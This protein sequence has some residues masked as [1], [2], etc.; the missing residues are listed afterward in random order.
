MKLLLAALL[1]CL[2]HADGVMIS[3]D[4]ST[5]LEMVGQKSQQ[6]WID[7]KDGAEKLT[8]AV[9]T[10]TVT[11]KLAWIIPIPAPAKDVKLALVEELP[12]WE[13]EELRAKARFK[14]LKF[15]IAA[16]FLLIFLFYSSAHGCLVLIAVI[17][18]LTAIAIPS[19]GPSP[20]STK[21]LDVVTFKHKELGGL[22]S[23]LVEAPSA[24]ALEAYLRTKS[25]SLPKGVAQKLPA[26][27]SFIVSWATHS[28]LPA[29]LAVVAT[30]PSAE[31]FY[32]MKLSSAYGSRSLAVDLRIKG[33]H[34]PSKE[35]RALESFR[36]GYYPGFTRALFQGPAEQLDGDWT[37]TP[38]RLAPG[39]WLAYGTA[40]HPLLANIMLL[41]LSGIA[42]ALLVC[43]DL[44]ALRIAGLGASMLLPYYWPASLLKKWKDEQ[45]PSAAFWVLHPACLTFVFLFSY[46][47]F[48]LWPIDRAPVIVSVGGDHGLIRK[49][50]EGATRGNLG[51][52]RS[53]L[54]IYYGDMEGLFPADPY[55]LTLGKK[56]MKTIPTAKLPPYH[57]DSNAIRLISGEDYKAGDLDDTG[58]W[59]YVIDGENTGTAAVNCL[60]TDTRQKSWVEY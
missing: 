31:P 23:E 55:T 28:A 40:K 14:L 3:Y 25:C 21:P 6:A 43:P 33:W 51:A 24:G 49:S 37:F 29:S 47:L 13:G 36:W 9:R 15:F 46:A 57:S 2:A 48:R 59:L 1:P 8:L 35:L 19:F 44:S 18:V 22:V 30:F 56:Y 38:K 32:P 10:S 4:P 50:N 16:Y 41:I 5:P 54:S 20:G 12:E 42:A 60:H 53:A 34:S 11:P 27:P 7:W 45:S 39:L 58:G 17:G 26:S 52:I